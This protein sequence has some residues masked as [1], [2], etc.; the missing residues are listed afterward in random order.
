VRVRRAGFA[1]RMLYSRFLARYKMLSPQTWPIWNDDESK[2]CRAIVQEMQMQEGAQYQMG[3]SKIFI[4]QPVSLFTME[5]LR[6]RKLHDIATMIQKIYRSW[7]ARK[8]FLELRDKSLGLFGKNKPRRRASIRRYYVGD[9]LNASRNPNIVNMLAK[10]GDRNVLFLDEVDKVN[11]NYKVQR[12]AIM[13]SSKGVYNL[14]MGKYSMNRRIPI[15]LITGISVS[16]KPDNLFVLHIPTEYDYVFISER[17][18]EFLTALCDEYKIETG[19]TL[20]LTFDNTLTYQ[21]KGKKK[22]TIVFEDGKDDKH[23]V[24]QSKTAKDTMVV[25]VP[26]ADVVLDVSKYTP[27]KMT[28]G[29]EKPK[30]GRPHIRGISAVPAN[31]EVAE[32]PDNKVIKKSPKAGA[33]LRVPE[34]KGATPGAGTKP[35]MSGPQKTAGGVPVNNKALP[36][37]PA[38]AKEMWYKGIE[39]FAPGDDREL[40]F[41]KGDA[42]RILSKDANGWWSGELNGKMGFVPETY[43]EACAPPVRKESYA[44]RPVSAKKR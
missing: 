21:L 1:F 18:T 12:R 15:N 42:I 16:R 14:N 41:K 22:G 36:A 34:S 28:K 3:K 10:N 35:G 27:A 8:Y 33:S 24:V 25:T 19:K 4:R 39:D 40:G 43:L 38:P 29:A 26:K 37:K 11:K 23:Y 5:E 31:I 44:G 7:K 9:Y 17:K 2:G 6:E 30:P 20:P 32:E 13:L